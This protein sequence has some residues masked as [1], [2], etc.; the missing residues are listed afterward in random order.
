MNLLTLCLSIC[1]QGQLNLTVVV[2]TN[3]V[4][5]GRYA[6]PRSRLPY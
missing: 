1:S 2:E 6:W 3:V 5:L 4:S